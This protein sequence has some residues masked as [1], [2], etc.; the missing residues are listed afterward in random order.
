[1]LTPRL[2]DTGSRFSNTKISANSKPKSEQLEIFSA[3][4]LGQSDLCKKLGKFGSLPCPFKQVSY[5]MPNPVIVLFDRILLYYLP[6]LLFSVSSILHIALHFPSYSFHLFIDFSTSFFISPESFSMSL[7]SLF[8]RVM[9]CQF[10]CTITYFP[11]NGFT[12]KQNLEA[13]LWIFQRF[14]N[15]R[16]SPCFSFLK[17]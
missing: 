3:R 4:D 17:S 15:P 12:K 9:Y 5:S 14:L 7:V 11:E 10:Y 6:F 1:L 2:T 13:S 16:A 8:C